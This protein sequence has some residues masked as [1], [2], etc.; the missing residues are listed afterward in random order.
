MVMSDN[1]QTYGIPDELPRPRPLDG[2]VPHAPSRP[3]V[4]NGP[5]KTLAI[6]NALRY[7]PKEWHAELG[8][9]FLTELDDFSGPFRT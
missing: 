4:L 2:G 5:E 8:K 6:R 1:R 7:F 9:E 3:Q